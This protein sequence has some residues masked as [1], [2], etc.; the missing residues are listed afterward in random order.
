MTRPVVNYQT[1]TGDTSFGSDANYND[2]GRKDTT[3]WYG[4][5]SNNTLVLRDSSLEIQTHLLERGLVND[6]MTLV[7]ATATH[8]DPNWNGSQSTGVG[9]KADPLVVPG[10][11]S[12]HYHHFIGNIFTKDDDVN[13]LLASNNSQVRYEEGSGVHRYIDNARGGWPARTLHQ[14]S[15]TDPVEVVGHF[16]GVWFP[17][18][19]W[20]GKPVKIADAKSVYYTRQRFY[21]EDAR[22]VALPS[23]A[24]WVSF[25]MHLAHS[26]GP[27]GWRLSVRGPDWFDLENLHFGPFPN[28]PPEEGGGAWTTFQQDVGGVGFGNTKPNKPTAFWTPQVQAYLGFFWPN[29]IGP[30]LPDWND[31]PLS[32]KDETGTNPA[33]GYAAGVRGAADSR[34][35]YGMP[36]QQAGMPRVPFHMDYISAHG[37]SFNQYATVP[38]T[39]TKRDKITIQRRTYQIVQN[40]LGN[41]IQ[42]SG[43]TSQ[44]SI[45][46]IDN[47]MQDLIDRSLNNNIFGLGSSHSTGLHKWEGVIATGNAETLPPSPIPEVDEGEEEDGDLEAPSLSVR[48]LQKS[49]DGLTVKLDYVLSI[50]V[51]SQ[52]RLDWNF[53]DGKTQSVAD[54]SGTIEHTYAQLG[55]YTVKL[56]VTDLTDATVTTSDELTIE[57]KRAP[58]LVSSS[59]GGGLANPVALLMAVATGGVDG[60]RKAVQF[61]SDADATA[62]M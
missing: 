52:V 55:T 50:T 23:G 38:A 21:P 2:K 36:K 12:G 53:G 29:G 30:D 1:T 35:T 20:R 5:D 10:A 14:N 4:F 41:T 9:L 6:A 28:R 62:H 27:G 25:N 19:F 13:N 60:Q 32:Y 26:G 40:P 43:Y 16:P 56:T 57:L 46:N 58:A 31:E 34:W 8:S 48:I 7:T 18:P 22:L 33:L 44:S 42:F 54:G 45:P 51:R 37:S 17:T 11:E 24:G 39:S 61:G 15:P 49:I 47:F 3:S 59:A